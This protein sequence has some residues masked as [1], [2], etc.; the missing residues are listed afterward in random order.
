MQKNI[1]DANPDADLNVYVVWEPLLGG[2]RNHAVE[3]SGLMP[4]P[5]VQHFWNEPFIVG[6]FYRDAALGRIAWDIYFL[7]GPEAEWQETPEPLLSSG[8]TV[9]AKRQQLQADF[10]ALLEIV[11]P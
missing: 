4:D 2:R 11:K 1:L 9:Y 3:A 8:Y 7:Y 10:T 5:R 6:D